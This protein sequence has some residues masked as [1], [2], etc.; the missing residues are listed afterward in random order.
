VY[1]TGGS[2]TLFVTLADVDNDLDSDVIASNLGSSDASLL[3]NNGYGDFSAAELVALPIMTPGS[4]DAGDL[5]LDGNIDFVI[6]NWL[7]PEVVVMWGFGNASFTAGPIYEVSPRTSKVTLADF[8]DDCDLD[9]VVTTDNSTYEPITFAYFENDGIHGMLT[10]VDYWL[11]GT[12]SSGAIASRDVNQDGFVDLLI[13]NW[14]AASVF[15]G[16]GDG[17][18]AQGVSYGVG[19]GVQA[20]TAGDLDSDSDID[21]GTANSLAGTF[22]ILWNQNCSPSPRPLATDVDGNGQVDLD[23]FA[24]LADCV[25]GP[26]ACSSAVVCNPPGAADTDFD[27]DADVDLRDG[28]ASL[29]LAR[30]RPL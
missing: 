12:R 30:P 18:F 24:I 6:S 25:S 16:N 13:S 10:P 15:L 14:G 17:T 21:V 9:V 26:G 4:I 20:I 2:S 7:Q 8:D 3:R 19:S 29:E 23:D 28:R 5:D 1:F 11:P 22:S 27:G